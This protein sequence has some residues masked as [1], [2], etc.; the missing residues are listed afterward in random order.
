M[1]DLQAL[2]HN[3]TALDDDDLAKVKSTIRMQKNV[4][5]MLMIGGAAA[6]YYINP[7][8]K[9]LLPR[10]A[11]GWFAGLAFGGYLAYK[12]FPSDTPSR[13]SAGA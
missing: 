9:R 1:T 6:A 7:T 11:F 3:P 12:Q 2:F 8:H 13:Y 5:S 10:M 4:P